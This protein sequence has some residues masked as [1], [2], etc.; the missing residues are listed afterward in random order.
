M[1]ES[2]KSKQVVYQDHVDLTQKYI[3]MSKLVDKAKMAMKGEYHQVKQ[4][5]VVTEQSKKPE[6]IK[7]NETIGQRA[8]LDNQ[9]VKKYIAEHKSLLC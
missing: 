1:E 2:K 4:S 9:I 6:F 5:D 7:I 3:D 8:L